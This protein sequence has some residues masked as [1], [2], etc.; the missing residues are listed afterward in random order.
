VIRRDRITVPVDLRRA[1]LDSARELA[2]THSEV[3]PR[4]PS[5][6]V[7]WL[8]VTYDRLQDLPLDARAGF[9]VSLIDGKCTVEM[10][11]DISGMGRDET[12]GILGRLVTLGAVE[13]RDP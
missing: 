4:V 13:L 10:L 2:P 7:P 6:A 8:L 11:L 3:R 12:L 1:A 5:S 9:L